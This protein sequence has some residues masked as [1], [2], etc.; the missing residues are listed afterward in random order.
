MSTKTYRIG[1]VAEQLDLATSALRYWEAK[2]PQIAPGRTPKGQRI[3]TEKNIDILFK[4]KELLYVRGMTMEGAK[5]VLEQTTQEGQLQVEQ[6]TSSSRLQEMLKARGITMETALQMLDP[7]NKDANYESP[8][9][10]G[11]RNELENMKR[12]LRGQDKDKKEE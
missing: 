1:E 7:S 3:Y 12:Q 2:F 5:Q 8:L 9:L 4:L 11:I 10:M 6:D